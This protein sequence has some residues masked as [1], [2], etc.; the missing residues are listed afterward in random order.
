MALS[1]CVCVHCLPCDSVDELEMYN[2][3]FCS[4]PHAAR[5]CNS[6]PPPFFILALQ[7]GDGA[8]PLWVN[9]IKMNSIGASAVIIM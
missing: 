2:T 8:G 3:G 6:P 4:E 7:L 1:V 9:S 5:S